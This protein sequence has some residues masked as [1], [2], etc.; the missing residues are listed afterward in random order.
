MPKAGYIG[1]LLVTGLI[2]IGLALA[3]LFATNPLQIGPYGVTIWFLVVLAGLSCLLTVGFDWLANRLN[4][5][6]GAPKLFPSARR[7]MLMAGWIT[8]LLGLS[9]LQQLSW[10]DVLLTGLLIGL[11]EFYFGAKA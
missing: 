4:K 10:R 1:S 6:P 5:K 9:S 2:A 11:A 3:A 7:G 8:I